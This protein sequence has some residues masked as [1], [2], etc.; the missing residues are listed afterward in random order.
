MAGCGIAMPC[1]VFQPAAPIQ[2]LLLVVEHAL[3]HVVHIGQQCAGMAASADQLPER[4]LLIQITCH[5]QGVRRRAFVGLEADPAVFDQQLKRHWSAAG[6][7][8]PQMPRCF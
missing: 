5:Q 4:G 2:L 1:Q 8:K 6:G 7:A 3:E